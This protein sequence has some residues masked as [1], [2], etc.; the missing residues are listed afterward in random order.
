VRAVLQQENL[1]LRSRRQPVSAHV[2][3]VAE[4]SDKAK[5]ARFIPA[6]KDGDSL[7]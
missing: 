1:L 5:A 3:M 6:M 2:S 4:T 7:A